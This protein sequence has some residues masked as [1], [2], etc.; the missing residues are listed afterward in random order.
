MEEDCL[1]I[2]PR[3]L[4]INS[5]CHYILSSL[6]RCQWS[7]HIFYPKYSTS[8]PEHALCRGSLWEAPGEGCCPGIAPATAARQ[9]HSV[10][11]RS[12]PF[13]IDSSP[14][15]CRNTAKVVSKIVVLGDSLHS[16]DAQA[17]T[18]YVCTFRN[19]ADF[20]HCSVENK[21]H[22]CSLVHT[23]HPSA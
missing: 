19:N 13:H 20:K 8:Q 22:V 2:L 14:T 3:R 12:G 7:S 6:S 9:C 4:G 11:S 1:S 18:Q 15:M 5:T 23:C 17:H 16:K 21:E 10:P